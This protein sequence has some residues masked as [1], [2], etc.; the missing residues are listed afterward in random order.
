MLARNRGTLGG[1]FEYKNKEE[2]Y[3]QTDRRLCFFKEP[4]LIN[5][6]SQIHCPDKSLS[7]NKL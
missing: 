4:I 2:K 1:C 3:S 5:L 6:F 7:Q